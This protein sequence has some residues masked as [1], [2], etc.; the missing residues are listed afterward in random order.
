[1]LWG[2]ASAGFVTVHTWVLEET[3]GF[4]E[5]LKAFAEVLRFLD[6]EGGA[7]RGAGSLEPDVGIGV[8]EEFGKYEDALEGESPELAVGEVGHRFAL[9]LELG[10][11]SG[12]VHPPVEGGFADVRGSCSFHSRWRGDDVGESKRLLRSELRVGSSVRNF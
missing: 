3:E 2:G 10:A 4:A 8:V 7:N 11:E 6:L 12:V 9:K 5:N 1:M